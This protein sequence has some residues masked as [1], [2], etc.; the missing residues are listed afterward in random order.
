MTATN[1]DEKYE[2]HLTEYMASMKLHQLNLDSTLLDS[3][4]NSS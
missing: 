1:E 3:Q 2:D 4:N